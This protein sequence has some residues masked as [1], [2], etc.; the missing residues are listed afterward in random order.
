MRSAFSDVVHIGFYAHV[1]WTIDDLI[2]LAFSQS[3]TTLRRLS[4]QKS[5]FETAVREALGPFAVDGR[6]TALIE[7]SAM[8]ARRPIT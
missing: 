7:H 3:S 5:A 4:D 1:T 2:G 8:V 6:L